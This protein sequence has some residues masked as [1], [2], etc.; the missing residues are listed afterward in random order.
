MVLFDAVLTHHS[1]LYMRVCALEM[2]CNSLCVE[3]VVPVNMKAVKS[4]I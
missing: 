3:T 1:R 4:K 2:A